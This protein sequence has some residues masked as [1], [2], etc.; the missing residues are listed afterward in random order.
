MRLLNAHILCAKNQQVILKT[1]KVC[2]ECVLDLFFFFFLALRNVATY[3]G[4]EI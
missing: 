4:T 2:C 1:Q 3:L